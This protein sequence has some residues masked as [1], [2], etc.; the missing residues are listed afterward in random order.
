MNQ[1]RI[2]CLI[3][4]AICLGRAGD[5]AA[6]AHHPHETISAVFN[7]DRVT[8]V[9]AALIRKIQAGETRKI[10]ERWFPMA[11]SGDRIR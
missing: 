4:A 2:T 8:L 9:Y 6:E 11:R 10:W 1:H 3:V 5:G 7:G